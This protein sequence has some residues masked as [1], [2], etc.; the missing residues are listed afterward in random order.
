M[1]NKCDVSFKLFVPDSFKCVNLPHLYSVGQ[2]EPSGGG[3]ATQL[4]DSPSMVPI[5]GSTAQ[6]IS[7]FMQ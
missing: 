3:S 7:P 1:H 2:Q 5:Q 6:T 4:S